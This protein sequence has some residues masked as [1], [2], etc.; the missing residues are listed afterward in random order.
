[1]QTTTEVEPPLLTPVFPENAALTND[2]IDTIDPVIV[3]GQ[4]V[5]A[6]EIPYQAYL[7]EIQGNAVYVCGGSLVHPVWVF[8]AAH[9]IVAPNARTEVYL[10]GTNTNRMSYARVASRRI[11]HPQYNSRSI[12]NDVGLLRLPVAA[13]GPGI[14]VISLAPD[15]VGNLA[16]V[17][18]QVSGYGRT[19]TQGQLSPD[20]LKA[21]LR[22][23]SNQECSS[24]FGSIPP[25]ELCANWYDTYGQS[26]C[27]GDS[28]GPLTV[29]YNGQRVLAGVVS[30]TASAQSGG[31]DNALPQGFAR[32]TSFRA[33]AHDTMARNS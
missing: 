24:Q 25:S 15:A 12:D 1:M 27:Q 17:V 22:G 2:T 6:G 31:C 8:T 9:C 23:I 33:W 3:R 5:Q 18:M 16:G 21:T 26:I 30:Y 14:G 13:S 11:P 29:P 7:R 28:G 4:R 10:G 19:A 20:L 32:V